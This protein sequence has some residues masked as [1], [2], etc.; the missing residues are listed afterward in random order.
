[1]ADS[2]FANGGPRRAPKERGSR[3]R[4]AERRRREYRGAE[5]AEGVVFGEGVSPSPMQRGLRRGHG[6][7]I[8]KFFDFESENG[9]F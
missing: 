7:L 5:G 2:G 4:V 9:D 3:R 6:P 1:V 8:R